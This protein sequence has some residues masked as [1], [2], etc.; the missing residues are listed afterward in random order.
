MA[1]WTDIADSL[2]EPNK[3]ARGIDAMALRDNPIAIAEGAPGAPKIQTALANELVSLPGA[4]V[5]YFYLLPGVI[6]TKPASGSL[7]VIPSLNNRE[8][9]MAASGV[10]T[11]S[12]EIS[13]DSAFNG[14]LELSSGSTILAS[15]PIGSQPANVYTLSEANTASVGFGQPVLA[16]IRTISTSGTDTVRVRNLTFKSANVA[17]LAW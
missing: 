1:T 10:I 14:A 4:F 15:I 17:F 16:Q 9:I 13:R 11:V 12:A 8:A 6:Y 2:L 5:G 3:P 7:A